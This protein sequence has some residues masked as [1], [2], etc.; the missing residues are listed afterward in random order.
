MIFCYA[1]T[2]VLSHHQRSLLLQQ[3]EQIQR[4]QPD[5]RQRVRGLGTLDLMGCFHQ[6]LPSV[7]GDRKS[8]RAKQGGGHQGNTDLEIKMTKAHVTSQRLKQRAQC[9][10]VSALG[11]LHTYYGL[12]CFYGMPKCANEWVSGSCA[13][14]WTR[15]LLFV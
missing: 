11:P 15:F 5:I 1:Y 3:M 10:H 6:I 8:V 2:S 13:F 14:S 7:L 12:Q 9:L 4:P